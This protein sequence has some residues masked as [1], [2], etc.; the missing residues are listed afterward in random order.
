MA[1]QLPFSQRRYR[2]SYEIRSAIFN[3]V[4]IRPS[5]VALALVGRVPPK[6][7]RASG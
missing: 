6:V 3:A 4:A 5:A 2:S 1:D 7:T